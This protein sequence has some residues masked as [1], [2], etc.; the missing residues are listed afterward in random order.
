MVTHEDHVATY[1]RRVIRVM[2]G[3]IEADE[4]IEDRR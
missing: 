4:K 3:L 2:D 1:A